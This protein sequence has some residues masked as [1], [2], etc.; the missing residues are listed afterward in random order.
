MSYITRRILFLANVILLLV[1][2][3]I[4]IYSVFMLFINPDDWLFTLMLLG[5]GVITGVFFFVLY[6]V[7]KRKFPLPGIDYK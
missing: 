6:V 3:I 2:C 7:R 5:I 4:C 1:S